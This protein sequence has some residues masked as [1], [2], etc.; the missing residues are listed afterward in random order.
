ML[1]SVLFLCICVLYYCHRVTTQLQ[2]NISYRI[3]SYLPVHHPE[4][5]RLAIIE[6]R[7]SHLTTFI[8]ANDKLF[9][10]TF[11]KAFLAQAL[12]SFLIVTNIYVQEN[13]RNNH[14]TKK[15]NTH[16]HRTRCTLYHTGPL[17]STN[18]N[19]C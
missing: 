6:P 12:S 16:T 11:S 9:L 13:P 19:Y 10:H 8:F 5:K 1:F 7:F 2:L 15:K 17:E 18:L 14:S 3:I 4:R